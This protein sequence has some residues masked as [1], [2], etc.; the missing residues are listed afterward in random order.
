[1]EQRHEAR[2]EQLGASQAEF[3]RRMEEEVG[4]DIRVEVRVEERVE[5]RVTIM[6]DVISAGEERPSSC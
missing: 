3:I 4:G 1:M 5:V 2:V 6:C